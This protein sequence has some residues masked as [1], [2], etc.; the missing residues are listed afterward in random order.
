[1]STA[2][3][4]EFAVGRCARPF[5]ALAEVER[6]IGVPCPLNVHDPSALAA[7]AG[8]GWAYVVRRAW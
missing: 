5:W 1:V 4:L 7:E 8:Y 6:L 3:S 2:S